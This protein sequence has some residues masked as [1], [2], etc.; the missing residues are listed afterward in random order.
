MYLSLS[1]SLSLSLSLSHIPI[2]VPLMLRKC[3]DTFLA[4]VNDPAETSKQV[5]KLPLDSL[6]VKRGAEK[7][8]VIA[9]RRK[10]RVKYIFILL[11]MVAPLTHDAS[12]QVLLTSALISYCYLYCI[13]CERDFHCFITAVDIYSIHFRCLNH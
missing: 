4:L 13:E 1:P 10:F 8:T 7:L 5:V 2:A 12:Y 3:N 11:Y 6:K 9:S